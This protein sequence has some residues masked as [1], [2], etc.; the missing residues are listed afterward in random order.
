[1]RKT[2]TDKERELAISTLT[3]AVTR[4]RDDLN[5]EMKFAGIDISPDVAVYVPAQLALIDLLE[6]QEQKEGEQHE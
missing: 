6:K 3:R 1:M 4:M 2:R 5:N